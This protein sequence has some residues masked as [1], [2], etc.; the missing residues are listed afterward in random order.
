MTGNR[1]KGSGVPEKIY[2]NLIDNVRETEENNTRIIICEAA[3][4]RQDRIAAPHAAAGPQER[5]CSGLSEKRMDEDE[6]K[7]YAV[8]AGTLRSGSLQQIPARFR[9]CRCL[10]V[11]GAG[12]QD[13][14]RGILSARMDPDHLLLFQD[15]FTECIETLCGEPD[16]SGK[17]V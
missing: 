17:D 12:K 2:K 13:S 8:Y 14:G 16:I 7:I 1:E 5:R 4:R 9:S 3:N 11:G 10:F 6:R 15:V